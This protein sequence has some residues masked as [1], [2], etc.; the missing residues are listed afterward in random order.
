MM[1][2]NKTETKIFFNKKGHAYVYLPV[3]ITG[4]STFPF[5]LKTKKVRVRI[6]GKKLIIEKV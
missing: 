4:D 6:E 2:M 5:S 1:I 3:R